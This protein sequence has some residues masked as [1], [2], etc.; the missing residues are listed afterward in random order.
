[1]KSA[2]WQHRSTT[3]GEIAE[4]MRRSGAYAFDDAAY[5]VF[6]PLA[7]RNGLPVPPPMPVEP[8]PGCSAEDHLVH[9]RFL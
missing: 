8:P 1:M 4:G 7:A 3:F 9:I 5:E 2:L 6:Y